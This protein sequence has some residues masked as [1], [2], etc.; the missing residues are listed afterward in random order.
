MIR[1]VTR[2]PFA[3]CTLPMYIGFILSEPKF[4]NCCRLS[5]VMGISHDSVNRFLLRENYTPLDL[6]NHVKSMLNLNGGTISV[7]DTVLDK[8]YSYNMDLIGYFWSGKHHRT[9]KGINLI[10]L[11]YTD[12]HGKHMPINYRLYDKSEGKTKN[13][14]FRE[15]LA[16]VLEWGVNPAFVTGDCWYSGADNLKTVRNY[17]MGWLFALESNRLVSVSKGTWTQVQDL[18]LP[19]EGLEVWLRGFGKVKLFRTWLKEQPRHYA[20]YLPEEKALISFDR[21][22]FLHLHDQHWQIEQY[23][24]VVKQVCHIERF[25]VRKKQAIRNHIFSALCAYKHLNELRA[26]D[27]IQSCYQLRRDLFNDVIAT[28]IRS[29][30]PGKENLNPQFSSSVNA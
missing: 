8:P 21:K 14:Y 2:P 29:F 1:E 17:L 22:A 4:L 12:V 13:E 18:E 16:E 24:R 19:E 26:T 11:Y 15:M 9:V 25:Q 3:Q 6:F 27:V 30:M 7:D 10:T 28:F 5:E 23:H 20:V